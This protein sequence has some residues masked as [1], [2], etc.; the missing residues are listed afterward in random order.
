MCLGLRNEIRINVLFTKHRYCLIFAYLVKKKY[1]AA[2]SR[3]ALFAYEIILAYD[4]TY[5][6]YC[7]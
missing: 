2:V 3:K 5:R 4:N 6:L 7:T 1:S